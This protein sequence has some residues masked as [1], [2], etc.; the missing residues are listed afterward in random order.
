MNPKCPW[1]VFFP[2]AKKENNPDS[3]FKNLCM[4]ESSS[5]VSL[6][7]AWRRG[8]G[9]ESCSEKLLYDLC[10]LTFVKE[11][12]ELNLVPSTCAC[13]VTH[14]HSRKCHLPLTHSSQNSLYGAVKIIQ[15]LVFLLRT[16]AQCL[17]GDVYQPVALRFYKKAF[18]VVIVDECRCFTLLWHP[19]VVEAF[20]DNG[21]DFLS[22]TSSCLNMSVDSVAQR[23]DGTVFTSHAHPSGFDQCTPGWCWDM[24]I[25][26]DVRSDFLPTYCRNK[27]WSVTFERCQ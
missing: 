24:W 22:N 10:F 25:K 6:R 21:C 13:G 2:L 17:Y 5:A 16:H 20:K 4:S 12:G 23:A 15:G 11:Q 18:I 3:I 9:V 8:L 26:W 7:W 19:L 14:I 27:I 1:N